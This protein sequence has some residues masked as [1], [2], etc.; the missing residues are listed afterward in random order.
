MHLGATNP[1]NLYLVNGDRLPH[2]AAEVDLGVSFNNKWNFDDQINKSIKKANS[3]IGWVS[4]SVICRNQ[5]VMTNIYKSVIRPHLE[6]CVQ[7]WAPAPCHGNWT[8]IMSI[9]SVQ[10]R[11]T[12]MIDE[13]GLLTYEKRLEKLQL[14]TLLERR[15]RGDLIETFKILNGFTSY[16]KSLFSQ[17]TRGNNILIRPNSNTRDKLNFFSNRVVKYWNK[18]PGCIKLIKN[19]EGVE[20][21]Q[22]LPSPLRQA[23]FVNSFK[24]KLCNFKLKNYNQPGNFWELSAEIYNR[25]NDSDR[26]SFAEFMLENPDV[27]RRRR[28]NLKV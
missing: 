6:Y 8:L 14:T 16:G 26:S 11:F 19:W 4:R 1:Q 23:K 7:L 21:W 5:E 12:R 13:V 2:T 24:R 20:D 3:C 28:I 15:A 10:R 22:T 27:A 17:S 18:L 9:E 25:I